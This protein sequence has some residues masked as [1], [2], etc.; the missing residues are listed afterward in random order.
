MEEQHQPVG[1]TTPSRST[2]IAGAQLLKALGHAGFD[3]MLL[4]VDLQNS[5]AGK[6]SGLAGRATSLAQYALANPEAVTPEGQTIQRAIVDRAT[7][8]YRQGVMANLGTNDRGAFAA[9]TTKDGIPID[10]EDEKEASARPVWPR[11]TRLQPVSPPTREFPTLFAKPQNRKV[12][13]VHGHDE[14]AREKVARFLEKIDFEAIILHERANQGRTIIE[15]FEANSDVGFAVVL[16]TAD[17]EGGKVGEAHQRRAR[18]NVLLEWGYFI[19]KLGR[20]RVCALKSGN[21]ELPSDI[22]GVVWE[23]MDEHRAWKGKLAKELHAAGYE[24]AWQ[25]VA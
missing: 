12:F 21:L 4:E 14:G 19:G 8:L 3:H 16:L 7:E 23:P 15:K 18:Q 6:G 25:K 2:V 11:P 13:I 1:Q 17:D 24:I 9:A 22:V 20:E 5:E 10:S